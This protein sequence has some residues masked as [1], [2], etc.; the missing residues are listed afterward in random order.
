LGPTAKVLICENCASVQRLA[1]LNHETSITTVDQVVPLDK[2][3][4]KR[5]FQPVIKTGGE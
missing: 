5:L 3:E 1:D 4:I 2:E